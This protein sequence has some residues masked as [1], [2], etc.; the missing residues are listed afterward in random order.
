MEHHLRRKH[1]VVFARP[2][3]DPVDLADNLCN[4]LLN[5]VLKE[6]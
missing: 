1:I 4:Y 6:V 3:L 2:V 5:D